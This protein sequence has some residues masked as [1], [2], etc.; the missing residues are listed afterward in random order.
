M[1]KMSA[2]IVSNVNQGNRTEIKWC[3]QGGHKRQ[4]SNVMTTSPRLGTGQN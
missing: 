2:R 3:Y 4:C 1:I